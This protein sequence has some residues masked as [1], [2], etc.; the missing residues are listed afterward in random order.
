MKIVCLGDSLTEGDYG[1]SGKRGI[2]NVKEENYPYFLGKILNAETV[3][4]GKCGYRSSHFLRFYEE[5]NVDLRGADY[6][7]IMLGTNGGQSAEGESYENTCYKRLVELCIRD[8]DNGAIVVLCTPPHATSNPKYSNCGY[9]PQITEAVGFVRR[10][11]SE[12]GLPL[13]DLAACPRFTE[14]TEDVMQPNDGLH[15]GE[16]GYDAM[17]EVIAEALIAIKKAAPDGSRKGENMKFL[18]NV[19]YSDDNDEL[20]TL[21]VYIPSGECKAVFL[22]IHGG[23]IETGAK[24][25]FYGN[26]EFLAA[27]GYGSVSIDYP[28]YPNTKFPDFLY[29]AAQAIAWTK[30]NMRKFFGCERLYVGGDSAGGYI[31][32]MLCFDRKYLA[33]VG[34]SNA[35]IVGYWHAA[36]QPTA[37]FNVLKYSGVDPRRVIVDETAPLY[38]IGLEESYPYM[39]FTVSDNDMFARYEQT[40]VV[41]K[42]LEHFGYKNFDLKVVSGTHCSYFRTLYEDGASEAAHLIYDFLETGEKL[43]DKGKLR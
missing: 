18:K 19:Y 4:Y 5:G 14:E 1:I 16:R 25:G 29:A 41:L 26:A 17:A 40:M 37:H 27:H 35:D 42:T 43:T 33:S 13:I 22:Y 3:N 28:L 15:F 24:W 2:A 9:M 30:K 23:G 6:V 34:L 11:A 8:S 10:F 36:G 21:N 32:M 12:I 38:F 39:R 7:V 20:K 31:S